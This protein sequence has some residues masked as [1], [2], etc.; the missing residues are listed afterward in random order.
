MPGPPEVPVG[1]LP[2]RGSSQPARQTRRPTQG[3]QRD[4]RSFFHPGTLQ[5]DPNYP[6][7]KSTKKLINNISGTTPLGPVL[8][9]AVGQQ[10]EQQPAAAAGAAMGQ[11]QEQQPPTAEAVAR[12]AP[13][14]RR[15]AGGRSSGSIS[16]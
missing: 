10:Q 5:P 8:G 11:Q 16:P 2:P 6:N 3:R 7:L 13:R 15:R 4:I 14:M 12:P 1:P 9:S